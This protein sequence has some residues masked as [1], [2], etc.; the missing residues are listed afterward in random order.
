[1]SITE[2]MT[3]VYA[4]H[5]GERLRNIR[6]QQGLSL[7]A[8]EEQS[9]REFKASV[10]GPTSGANGS[11]R[12][13]ACSASPACTASLLTSCCPSCHPTPT[14]APKAGHRPTTGEGR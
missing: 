12:S 13:C 5:V 7:Q 11:S 14:S 10:L 9:D 3:P 1:M 8:V 6:R 4:R 2:E